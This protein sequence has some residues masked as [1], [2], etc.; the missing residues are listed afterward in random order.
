MA[1][2]LRGLTIQHVLANALVPRAVPGPAQ[3]QCQL[4]VGVLVM[5]MQ[6]RTLGATTATVSTVLFK[7]TIKIF[8][9]KQNYFEFDTSIRIYCSLTVPGLL[10][11]G[12]N[13]I[14]VNPI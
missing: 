12:A 8:G 7:M 9:R 14:K 11:G 4:L 5:V 3:I 6:K 1:Y 2:G 10:L 13:R